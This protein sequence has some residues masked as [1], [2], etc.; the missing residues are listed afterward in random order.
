MKYPSTV[1]AYEGA[2]Q[3]TGEPIVLLLTG[4]ENPTSNVKTGQMVQAVVLDTSLK[5]TEAVKAGTDANV[6]GDCPL[7][8]GICY[9]NLIPFNGV[10]KAYSEGRTPYI[11][12]DV[13]ERAKVKCQKLRITAYG[14]PSAV[15]IEI[16]E[17]L[18]EYFKNHTGYTHQWRNLNAQAWAGR[19]MASVETKEGFSQALE[20]GWSTFRV[21]NAGES[22]LPGEI[23]CPNI[24]N[25][26]IQ[27]ADCR[28]CSGN[29]QRQRHISVEAHGLTHKQKAF[30][31]LTTAQR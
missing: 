13:L 14:D 20:A 18:L 31:S 30:A 3:L 1:I 10:F 17:S 9:V 23:E 19:L 6:C 26:S 7:K 8:R 12:Q 2:S 16:W 11:T 28:L 4:L 24:K 15:P 21:R 5:P 27:C 25:P 22:L 29:Q